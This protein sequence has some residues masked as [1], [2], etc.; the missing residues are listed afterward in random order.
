MAVVAIVAGYLIVGTLTAQHK[1]NQLNALLG[2]KNILP[3]PK[4]IELVLSFIYSEKST[5][6]ERQVARDTLTF[7]SGSQVDGIILKKIT[8]APTADARL[9]LCRILAD[10]N[11]EGAMPNLLEAYRSS[12]SGGERESMKNLM[13]RI[14]ERAKNS[15]AKPDAQGNL[16]DEKEWASTMDTYLQKIRSLK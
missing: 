7:M 13:T 16:P 8:K 9:T 6:Q 12:Q 4:V 2:Q 10:R 15:K 5:I 11:L 14:V 3:D 1:R